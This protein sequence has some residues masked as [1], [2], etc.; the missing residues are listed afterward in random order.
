MQGE[1]ELEV[2]DKAYSPFCVAT[3]LTVAFL[4]QEEYVSSGY[5]IT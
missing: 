2:P 4:N 5:G 3:F 1:T